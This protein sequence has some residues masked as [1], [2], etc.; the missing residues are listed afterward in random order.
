MCHSGT[1]A[2]CRR[3]G[4]MS[5]IYLTCLVAV[6]VGV[7][8]SGIIGSAW[9][10]LTDEEA[11]L[12]GIFNS[13]PGFLTPVRVFVSLAS[14]PATILRDAM[15]WMIAQPFAGVPLLIAGLVWSFMQGVFI[16][17]QVFGYS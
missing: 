9:E 8:S 16:L 17:T 13:D 7:V 11:R 5:S 12:G 3:V 14:A 4:L 6:I 2:A 10:L 15:W 1:A